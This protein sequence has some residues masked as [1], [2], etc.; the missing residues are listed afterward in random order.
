MAV[1]LPDPKMLT[2][3]CVISGFTRGGGDQGEL[4]FI[5]GGGDGGELK[6]E[7]AKHT[8]QLLREACGRWGDME[9]TH[10]PPRRSLH[11]GGAGA[12]LPIHGGFKHLREVQTLCCSTQQVYCGNLS[13]RR[14]C[15]DGKGVCSQIF[16]V[17]SSQRL[18]SPDMDP[19]RLREI[20][21]LRVGEGGYPVVKMNEAGPHRQR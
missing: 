7:I 14:T 20:P 8:E 1:R 6:T 13:Y 9:P 19:Q 15:S 4:S 16:I 17:C 10:Q 18:L 2:G 12:A 5:C 11:R 3:S 21:E